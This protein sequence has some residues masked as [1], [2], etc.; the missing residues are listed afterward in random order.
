MAG[1]PGRFQRTLAC[2]TSLLLLAFLVELAPHL[3]HHAFDE[4]HALNECP[5]ATAGERTDSACDDT[6]R[7]EVTQRSSAP[8]AVVSERLPA[9]PALGLPAPRAPPLPSR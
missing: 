2:V 3:V 8:A 5:F 9:R 6:A 4:H 1:G 7:G